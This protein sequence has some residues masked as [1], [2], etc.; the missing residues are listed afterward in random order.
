M[1]G[2]PWIV[3]NLVHQFALEVLER[4]NLTAD[5]FTFFAA[6]IKL[7]SLSSSDFG[8]KNFVS[9]ASV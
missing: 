3:L 8:E 2:V 1:R 9:M 6:A 4:F 5:L 7:M